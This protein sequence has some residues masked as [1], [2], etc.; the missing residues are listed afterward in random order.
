MPAASAVDSPVAGS[1]VVV[2]DLGKVLA[3][4]LEAPETKAGPLHGGDARGQGEKDSVV[5]DIKGD[6]GK[7][8]GGGEWGSEKLCRICH[9]TQERLEG[10]ESSE[11]ISLGCGCKDDLALS[12]RH[13]SEAWFKLKGNRTCEICGLVAKNVTGVE[14]GGFLEEWSERRS[15]DARCW[16]SQPLCNFLMAC[17]VIAFILPWFFR[18]NMF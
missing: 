4:P 2:V 12:H 13:C 5:L 6:A 17:L 8:P 9:L 15:G 7:G 3:A 18:V 16:R 11:L 10:S 1:G 14:D